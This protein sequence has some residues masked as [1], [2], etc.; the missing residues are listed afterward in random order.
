[1]YRFCF[2]RIWH[3][4]CT[5]YKSY[6]N[7][8]LSLSDS[9]GKPGRSL[10]SAVERNYDAYFSIRPEQNDLYTQFKYT[11]LKGFDY[12]GGDSTTTRR[13]TSKVSKTDGINAERKGLSH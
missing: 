11:K 5:K 9:P 8:S 12:N 6:C 10:S 13:D 2:G 7:K 3:A 4:G 1:M